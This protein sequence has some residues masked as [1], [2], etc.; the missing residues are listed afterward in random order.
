MHEPIDAAW[1]HGRSERLAHQAHV[2]SATDAFQD[3]SHEL[4][5]RDPTTKNDDVLI[6]PFDCVDI[7][8]HPLMRT[9]VKAFIAG[10]N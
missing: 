2:P 9:H 3:G 7:A 5:R 4:Y 8:R 1:Q 6:C 10:K